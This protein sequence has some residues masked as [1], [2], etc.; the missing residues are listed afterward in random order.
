MVT[1]ACVYKQGVWKNGTKNIEYSSKHVSWLKSMVQQHVSIPHRFVCLSDVPVDCER[2]ALLHG[3]AGWWSK[4]EL[5][6]PNLFE[7]PV[8]YIDLDTVVL[9]NI[10]H[11]LEQPQFTLLRNLS[12]GVGAGSGIMAW[13]GDQSYLYDIFKASPGKFMA[14][15]CRHG[16]RWGDQG[17]LQEHLKEQ[18][19]WQDLF[20]GEIKSF[21]FDLKSGDPQPGTKI[22]CFHGLPKPWDSGK[23]WVPPLHP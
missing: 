15:Y 1:I 4:M 11:L 2:V 20:P 18:I 19:Y 21:Y 5:Y 16:S 14:E 12:R 6:R 8:F 22:V 23:S 7:G 13:Q 17:F 10:D 9:G 3:W